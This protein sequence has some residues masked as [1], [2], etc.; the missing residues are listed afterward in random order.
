MQ[1]VEEN[2]SLRSPLL[3]HAVAR[4]NDAEEI[5][6]LLEDDLEG[7]L[8]PVGDPDPSQREF[9]PSNY[10]EKVSFDQG[11]GY[12][13]TENAWEGS[14]QDFF[15]T[16]YEDNQSVVVTEDREVILAPQE[17]EKSDWP[18]ELQAAHEAITTVTPE[19]GILA[20]QVSAEAVEEYTGW[21]NTTS[22]RLSDQVMSRLSDLIR[23]G[24]TEYVQS[25][26][27]SVYEKAAHPERAMD[28]LNGSNIEQINGDGYAF[29][30]NYE[31]GQDR[32][33]VQGFEELE[34]I[35]NAK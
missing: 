6:E 35:Y 18:H 17:A 29:T 33:T 27:S 8:R 28:R 12:F 7:N 24:E 4:N 34:D 9:E 26:A 22:L 3:E 32:V 10:V 31:P 1:P 25:F 2:I 23:E 30:W 20:Q 11:L 5:A 13:R 14:Q 21:E 16:Y 19:Y 15:I